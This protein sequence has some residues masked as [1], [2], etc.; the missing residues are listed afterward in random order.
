MKKIIVALLL[1]TVSCKD[2]PPAKELRNSVFTYNA[3]SK[4]DENMN[5]LDIPSSNKDS[6][7]NTTYYDTNSGNFEYNGSLSKI[8][9]KKVGGGDFSYFKTDNSIVKYLDKIFVLDLNFTIWELDQDLNK[10]RKLYTP[11]N[12]K[13]ANFASLT[14]YKNTVLHS[15]SNGIL[16]KID[17]E[18]GK[19]L[20]QVE[21]E[22][23]SFFAGLEH[24]DGILY[25]QSQSGD[26]FGLNAEDLSEIFS[27]SSPESAISNLIS[28]TREQYISVAKPKLFKGELIFVNKNN[29]IVFLNA[30]NGYQIYSKKLE[31]EIQSAISSTIFSFDTAMYSPF[32]RDDLGYFGSKIGSISVFLTQK[33]QQVASLP[34]EVNSPI[35][36]SQNF[37]YFI[38]AK[39]E[40]V[41]VHID[42]GRI[43]WSLPLDKYYDYKLPK[44]LSNGKGYNRMKLNFR[45]PIFVNDNILL[46]S[47]FG[48]MLLVDAENGDI[49]KEI[50]TQQCFFQ[51]PIITKDAIFAYSICDDRLYKFE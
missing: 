50:E 42:T 35:I 36:S 1:F 45:G 41:A 31:T 5:I 51:T 34:L 14:I 17:I 9:S 44:Y 27:Y 21:N 2:K 48:K 46:T 33:K 24:G 23:Y 49:K 40:L 30:K 39:N 4:I 18:S 29:E 15:Q 19:V 3:S 7:I 43:K 38:T 11:K 8:S 37:M 32:L 26:V 20:A 25:G 12:L 13:N 28:S 22:K 6:D 47:P 10:A 16:T